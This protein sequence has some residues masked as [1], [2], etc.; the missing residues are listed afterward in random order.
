MDM[1]MVQYNC[2]QPDLSQFRLRMHK[3]FTRLHI[4]PPADDARTLVPGTVQLE[5]I[6]RRFSAI[7]TKYCDVTLHEHGTLERH[8]QPHG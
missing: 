6:S 7:R 5:G 8:V 1:D 4:L 2:N 3:S